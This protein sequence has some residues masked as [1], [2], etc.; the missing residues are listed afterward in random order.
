MVPLNK[1]FP[2]IPTRKEL[3][4]IAVQSPL[5]K[6]LEARFLQK[7]QDYLDYK[8]DRSQT[9]FIRKMGVQ[10][11]LVRALERTTMRTK[12]RLCVYGLFIDFSNAYNS[13]PHSL[14]FKKLRE[15]KVLEDNEI[16]FLEQLYARYRLRIGKTRIRSNKGVAQGSVISPALFNIFIEDLSQELKEKTGISFEDLLY[17]ADD[18]LALCTSM[19]QVKSVIRIISDWSLRNGMQLNKKKS[20]IV[21]FT[22]RRSHDVPYMVREKENDKS[23]K[24]KLVPSR[25]EIEGVPICDKYKY[26]GTILTPKLECSEQISFIKRKAGFLL[27][28]LYPYLKNASADARRDMWQTMVKPLFNAA[29][30]LLEYEPSET[31]K[32]SLEKAWRGTFKYFMMINSRTPNELVNDM[33]NSNL[34]V[35]A[36]VLVQECRLQWD[37]RKNYQA[38]CP[39]RKSRKG[40][41]LL[42]GVSNRWCDI[43]N[44]QSGLCPKCM[45]DK[46]ICSSIHL[47]ERHGLIVKDIRKIWDEDI[48]PITIEAVEKKRNKVSSTL[49]R[50]LRKYVIEMEL[51]KAKLSQR[52]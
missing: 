16:D 42:R 43:I 13:I 36:S 49:Q 22:S 24:T 19:E 47:K 10:V 17:Y 40:I 32:E 27:V 6:L 35:T 3:R 8:L 25:P 4:P 2:K 12:K 48:C 52:D 9:G 5:V 50:T 51:T 31:N 28:K 39:K 7:L 37:L 46:E 20:G 11:N 18:L 23:K 34:Q 44:F 21:I 14:L 29:L 15:K 41:N 1:V 45:P 26:L 30:V 38:V 33:I